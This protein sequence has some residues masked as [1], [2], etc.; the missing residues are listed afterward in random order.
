MRIKLFI[1]L[2]IGFLSTFAGEIKAEEICYYTN[3]IDFRNCKRDPDRNL[4]PK[5]P[6]NIEDDMRKIY[7]FMWLGDE[8][9]NFQSL[10]LNEG[11]NDNISFTNLSIKSEIGKIIEFIFKEKTSSGWNGIFTKK[12][13]SLKTTK[14]NSEDILSWNFSYKDENLPGCFVNCKWRYSKFVINY[15]DDFG[16]RKEI[17][18]NYRTNYRDGSSIVKNLLRNISKLNNFEIRNEIDILNTKLKTNEKNSLII[19]SIIYLREDN[20]ETCFTAKDNKF[21]ELTA[22]YKKIYKTINPLRSKLDLPPSTEIKPICNQ[23]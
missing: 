19:K 4:L 21:P 18:G 6:L 22:R 7:F 2:F 20:N 5:Y 9:Y 16:N 11:F 14:I 12:Y 3:P 17:K 15:L 8:P 13:N 23:E 10:N 1:I